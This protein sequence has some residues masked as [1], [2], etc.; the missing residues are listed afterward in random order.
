LPEASR[1]AKATESPN[2]TLTEFG[3]TLRVGPPW[4]EED[5]PPGSFPMPPQ[6]TRQRSPQIAIKL[7]MI[8]PRFT[9]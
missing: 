1:A 7:R 2:S 4:S 9:P 3:L 6:L 5:P 8:C